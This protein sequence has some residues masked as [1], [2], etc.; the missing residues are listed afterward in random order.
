MFFWVQLIIIA[1]TILKFGT[2]GIDN[3]TGTKATLYTSSSTNTFDVSDGLHS[4]LA[5]FLMGLYHCGLM[6]TLLSLLKSTQQSKGTFVK[7]FVFD[8]ITRHHLDYS[9]DKLLAPTH[10][11]V[12]MIGY[13]NGCMM[14]MFKF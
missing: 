8:Y 7:L 11:V 9:I 1:I 10:K 2:T 6:S 4:Y 12:Q 5:G 13:L 14:I 3:G